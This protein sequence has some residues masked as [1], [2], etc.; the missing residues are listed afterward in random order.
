MR[1]QYKCKDCGYKFEQV[2]PVEC[3]SSTKPTCPVCYSKNVERIFSWFGLQ[4]NGRGF[5]KTDN[6]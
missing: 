3:L 5:Y 6:K 4:F 1:Y 2:I